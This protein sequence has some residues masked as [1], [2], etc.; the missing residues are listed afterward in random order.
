MSPCQLLTA[1]ADHLDEHPHDR[2]SLPNRMSAIL[3]SAVPYNHIRTHVVAAARVPA[4]YHPPGLAVI[5]ADRRGMDMMNEADAFITRR[6][7]TRNAAIILSQWCRHA[8]A[9]QAYPP[10]A[11]RIPK[12]LSM[13]FI[14]WQTPSYPYQQAEPTAAT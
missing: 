6:Y 4:E 13:P 7:G 3:K 10:T 11:L 1:T 14:R 12:P 2:I 5:C 8:A 9:G